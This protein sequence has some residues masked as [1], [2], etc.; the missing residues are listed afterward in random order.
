[1]NPKWVF[2]LFLV[3]AV[4]QLALPLG[5]I[6]KYENVLR[7][8]QLY[9]FRTAPVDPY[10]AFRGKYVALNYADTE[11]VMRKGDSLNRGQSAYVSL[12]KDENGFA[13]FAELA[14]APPPAGD[15]LRVEYQ[16][17]SENK[18]HFSV[19]FD[20]LFMEENKASQA[21]RAYWRYANRR[22][23]TSRRAYVLVRV[24]GGRGVIEDL[25]IEDQPVREF[26]K[27]MPKG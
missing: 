14:A 15:Y 7:S 6:W 1:M 13:Q 20:T 9:K 25:Y 11:A 10:D 27:T 24:K 3:L 4:V 19:P 17:S 12:R 2:G 5:Q 26:I 21:E 23:Q 18:A 8:G 16:D 22:D